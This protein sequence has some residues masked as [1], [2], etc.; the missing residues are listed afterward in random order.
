MP[1][2]LLPIPTAADGLED[3]APVLTLYP[4]GAADES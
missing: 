3:A 2:L 1:S 4:L